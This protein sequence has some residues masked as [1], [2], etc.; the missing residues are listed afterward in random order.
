GLTAV[1]LSGGGREAWGWLGV[2]VSLAPLPVAAVEGIIVGFTVSFLA[3]V[4]PE[5]LGFTV[6]D[7]HPGAPRPQPAVPAA[8]AVTAPP[9]IEPAEGAPPM[10]PSAVPIKTTSLLLLSA[11]ALLLSAAP[12]RAHPLEAEYRGP[13]KDQKVEGERWVG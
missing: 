5:M 6:P 2:L 1:G 8:Q 12:A 11:A 4:K 7:L 10:N 13:P 9:G 3:R